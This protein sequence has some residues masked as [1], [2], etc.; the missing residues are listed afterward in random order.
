MFGPRVT[1]YDEFEHLIWLFSSKSK[2][3]PERIHKFL[4][5]GMVKSLN[6]TWGELGSSD[7]GGNWK[8]NGAL[9]ENLYVCSKN[10]KAFTWKKTLID[11]CKNRI[12][13]SI[14]ELELNENVEFFL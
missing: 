13:F 4:Q 1:P 7:K 5:D 3:L 11:D 2:W 10:N 12:Q 8:T 14:K 9:S 6:W